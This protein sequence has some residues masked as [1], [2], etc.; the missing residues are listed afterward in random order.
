MGDLSRV[1]VSGPLER[2]AAGFAAALA[3][4][5]YTAVSAAF[6]LQLLAH[7]SRW[8]DAQGLDAWCLAPAEAERVRSFVDSDADP[9]T[10]SRGFIGSGG[11]AVCRCAGKQPLPDNEIVHETK[12]KRTQDSSPSARRTPSRVQ[13]DSRHR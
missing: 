10:A 13:C 6:Q 2:Y 4:Q 12:A 7:L 11:L 9:V 5:G 8:L 3:G 1:R